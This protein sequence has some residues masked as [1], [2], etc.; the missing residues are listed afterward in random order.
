LRKK[1]PYFILAVILT[2]LILSCANKGTITGGEKDVKPPVV[3]S[4][5]PE[6]FSRNISEKKIHIKF[7]E[8]FQLKDIKSQLIISP[9]LENDP[10]IDPHGKNLNIDLN[11][12]LLENTTYTLNFGNSI[13]DLNEGNILNNFLFVF[14]TGEILDS[15]IIKGKVEDA[16]TGKAVENVFVMLYKEV[17]DSIPYKKIPVYISKTDKEGKFSINNIHEG[18][19]K[20]FALKEEINNYIYDDIVNESI[21]YIDSLITPSATYKIT[22]DTINQDSIINTGNT[23]FFPDSFKIKL[24]KEELSDQ[25]LSDSDRPEREKCIFSF[26][27]SL[28][29]KLKFR[30]LDQSEPD[31]WYYYENNITN[32]SITLWIRD[33]IISNNDSLKF[34]LSFNTT[35]IEEGKIIEKDTVTLNYREIANTKDPNTEKAILNYST[36][37]SRS[38]SFLA[39]CI[40]HI[41]SLHCMQMLMVLH[42]KKMI[43]RWKECMLKLIH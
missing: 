4:C 17:E 15:L 38:G 30:L 25:Y 7:D 9:P 41:I 32:D 23:T 1:I 43:C 29:E 3:I 6:N 34:E 26:N 12:E 39:P 24:F 21:A 8:Y 42:I 19:Y 31:N 37:I 14:S 10:E 5:D 27:N 18:S 13:V 40:I 16:F 36:N 28:D 2:Q 33:S 20:L 11:D 35:D 22:N